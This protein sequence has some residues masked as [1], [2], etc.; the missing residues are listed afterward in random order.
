MRRNRVSIVV[1]IIAFILSIFGFS[2]ATTCNW[3]FSIVHWIFTCGI[4]G[5]FFFY[6]LL[7]AFFGKKKQ[8][9]EYQID[10]T[11]ILL[12]FS[13]PYL[14]D[15]LIGIYCAIF[16]VRL[17][18]PENENNI[19]REREELNQELQEFNLNLDNNNQCWIWLDKGKDSA[20][21]PCG[22]QCTCY[23]WGQR[24]MN[25]RVGGRRV[26]IIC[27]QPANDIIQIYL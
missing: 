20:F 26:C 11:W 12:V 5:S 1:N 10:E 2:G 8:K 15:L 27:R 14:I 24:Y 21:Y 18:E 19:L 7:Y 22:H 3:K 9:D 6:E 13:F 17:I 23:Q 25:N 16:T 4:V